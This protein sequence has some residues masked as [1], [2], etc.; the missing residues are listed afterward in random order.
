MSELTVEQLEEKLRQV[1]KDLDLLRRQGD[2]SRKLEV[3][4]E[5]R[6]YIQDELKNARNK[7][8]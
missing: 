3:L 1:D 7:N 2:A 8:A 5:Y 6:E 4:S